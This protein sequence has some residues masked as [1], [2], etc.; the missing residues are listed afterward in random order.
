[1]RKIFVR[2]FLKRNSTEITIL[3]IYYESIFSMTNVI[4]YYNDLNHGQLIIYHSSVAVCVW[5]LNRVKVKS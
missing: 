3:L 4:I 1:M 2:G 5:D